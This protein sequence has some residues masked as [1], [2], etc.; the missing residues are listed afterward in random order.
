MISSLSC[1]LW[2]KLHR[3]VGFH[4]LCIAPYVYCKAF[5]D[6][7]GPL[8]L[9]CL[10]K[11][12]PHTK[13]IYNCYQHFREHVQSGKIKIYQIATKLQTANI[14]TKALLRIFLF[15]I[16]K[17]FMVSNPKHLLRGSFKISC[18]CL[19]SQKV[20][21]FLTVCHSITFHWLSLQKLIPHH[22]NHISSILLSWY[23][24]FCIMST[25][26]SCSTL[27]SVQLAYAIYYCQTCGFYT[28]QVFFQIL[29]KLI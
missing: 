14:A 1:S 9:A 18:N 4:V 23:Q 3:M 13:H 7:S 26:N 25:Q 22:E 27:F 2:K 16:K 28:N 21:F 15:D 17:R 8:E 5:E 20:Y 11:L 24:F 19:L 6:S 29:L 12:R 10:P